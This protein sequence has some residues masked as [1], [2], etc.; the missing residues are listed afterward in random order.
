MRGKIAN[1]HKYFETSCTATVIT[2]F[3]ITYHLPRVIIFR[4]IITPAPDNPNHVTAY[5]A[6]VSG[7]TL[8]SPTVLSTGFTGNEIDSLE[9]MELK[10]LVSPL[11]VSVTI[12]GDKPCV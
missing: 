6:C 9:L 8:N 1:V 5:P 10:F 7:K 3:I 12:R 2:A 11:F 4:I